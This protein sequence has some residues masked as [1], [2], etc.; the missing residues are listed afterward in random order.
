MWLMLHLN[1]KGITI[2]VKILT[3][4]GDLLRLFFPHNKHIW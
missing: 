1:I 2:L 4:W 3:Y